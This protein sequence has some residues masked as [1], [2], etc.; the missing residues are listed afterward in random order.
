MSHGDIC[1][2]LRETFGSQF[3]CSKQGDYERIRTPYLYPDGDH[4]DLFC[5]V[6]D[7]AVT[8]TDLAET[9]NWLWMQSHVRHRTPKQ[10]RLIQEVCVTHGIEFDRGM[11]QAHRK[12]GESLAE[13]VTKVAQAALR[14]SDLWFVFRTSA[15]DSVAKGFKPSIADEVAQYLNQ[16]NFRHKRSEE[17]AGRSGHS[18]KVDFQVYVSEDIPVDA[19]PD[20]LIY[21]ISG[22]NRTMARKKRDHALVIWHDL[23][24][25]GQNCISLFNDTSCLWEDKDYRLLE[26]LSRIA[27]WSHPD[28]LV[29]LIPGSA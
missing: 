8:V 11:L 21:V 9:I 23:E 5:K 1:S 18:W 2:E 24:H 4:I 29:P 27:H 15:S 13:V 17:I 16:K 25:E 28:E 26:P 6:G 3:V 20:A 22:S 12:P 7:D 10:N 14:V 19:E